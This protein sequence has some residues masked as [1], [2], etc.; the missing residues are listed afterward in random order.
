MTDQDTAIDPALRERMVESI[1][2]LLPKVLKR[3]V[4][5][6]TA[7]TTLMEALGMSSTTG[8]ELVLELEER[9]EVE[10]SVEDLGRGDFG[11]VGSLADYVAGNILPEA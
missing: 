2:A 6:A 7:D 9:L 1:C 5:G 11:T 8:L 10:I 4:S 3:E